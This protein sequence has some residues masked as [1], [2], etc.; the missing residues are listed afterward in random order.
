M[1]DAHETVGRARAVLAG[2]EELGGD[3]LSSLAGEYSALCEQANDRLRRCADLLL[4]G[5][6][7]EA[8]QA[9]EVK[10][11]LLDLIATLD[12]VGV[13]EWQDLCGRHGLALPPRLMVD[14]GTQLSEAYA[15]EQPLEGLKQRFRTL[16]L[17]RAPLRERLAVLRVLAA[18][19]PDV[20]VLEKDVAAHEQV[21]ISEFRRELAAA[22]AARDLPALEALRSEI[23]SSR[24]RVPVPADL[25]SRT[26][27]EIASARATAGEKELRDL[28]PRLQEAHGALAY[29]EAN[30]LLQRWRE[31]VESSG[32]SSSHA[33]HEEVRPLVEWVESESRLKQ[34]E[35]EFLTA[36]DALSREIDNPPGE[37][38]ALTQLYRRASSFDRPLLDELQLRY[39]RGLAIRELAAQ[40]RSRLRLGVVAGATLILLLVVTVAIGS[41]LERRRSDEWETRLA[42]T[43]DEGRFEEATRLWRSLE[44]SAPAIAARPALLEQKLRLDRALAAEDARSEEYRVHMGRAARAGTKAPDRVALE[45]ARSLARTVDEK[46]EVV[47]LSAEIEAVDA[48]RRSEA[49]REFQQRANVVAERV[50]AIDTGLLDRDPYAFGTVL[51]SV[52]SE[53]AGLRIGTSDVAP[54]FVGRTT[55]PL[56]QKLAAL[57]TAHA[58]AI[59]RFKATRQEQDSVAVLAAETGSVSRIVKGLEGFIAAHPSAPQAAGFRA[60]LADA[61][62]WHAIERWVRLTVTWERPSPHSAL[63]AKRR[64]EALDAFSKAN[65]GSPLDAGIVRYR[66]YVAAAEAAH[67]TGLERRNKARQILDGWLMRLRSFRTVA[68]K[69]YYVRQDT[70]LERTDTGWNATV[71]LTFDVTRPRLMSLKAAE[72]SGRPGPSP[73]S[74]LRAD[75]LTRLDA[76]RAEQ[77]DTMWLELAETVRSH[78][79]EVHPVLR[80]LLLGHFLRTAKEAGCGLEE[81]LGRIL[82]PLSADGLDTVN[83]LDPDDADGQTAAA[84]MKVVL[85]N[86]PKL[87]DL[88]DQ[89]EKRRRSILAGLPLRWLG[90]G[91]LMRAAGTWEVRGARSGAAKGTRIVVAAPQT[92]GASSL[93]REIGVVGEQGRI[94]LDGERLIDVPE[95]TP[96]FLVEPVGP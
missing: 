79:A 41:N 58:A 90:Q 53:V 46:L 2:E 70:D 84:R 61:E 33:L 36:C 93:L 39:E 66:K 23:G 19:Q 56:E 1:P 26:D 32:I 13:S 20:S 76:A 27:Q 52:Q 16:N 74:I 30:A 75:L 11:D 15:S 88:R 64:I 86:V 48:Q 50:G 37:A 96:A 22:A 5:L 69:T 9:A 34:R 63:E 10:P 82:E 38:A 92:G 55:A 8:I 60:A 6:R 12:S 25:V 14:K 77:W 65:P 3:D 87:L 67:I 29:D 68:G 49:E 44:E 4:R 28:L 57:S 24:W 71:L 7:T 95:G 62:A 73:Q 43:L 72:F 78:A 51:A 40:R 91:L 31:I 17:T 94:E 45:K 42:R 89:V 81:Q 18:R 54:E 59:D 83:W 47:S 21:R 85:G 80:A 35:R